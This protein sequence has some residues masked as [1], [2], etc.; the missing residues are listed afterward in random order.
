MLS[1]IKTKKIINI[2]A[3]IEEA[4]RNLVIIKKDKVMIYEKNNFKN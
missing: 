2:Y 4:K 1:S 3:K